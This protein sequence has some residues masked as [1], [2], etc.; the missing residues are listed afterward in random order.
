MPQF[1]DRT[2]RALIP[3][4]RRELASNASGGSNPIDI[5]RPELRTFRNDSA[6]TIPAFGCMRITDA[7]TDIDTD[8]PMIVVGKPNSTGGPFI[9]NGPIEV[10]AGKYGQYQAVGVVDAYYTA[11][12]PT[13]GE[14]W[15]P[16]SNWAISSSGDAA[17][18][19]F[20]DVASGQIRGR[21][22]VAT[23]ASAFAVKL[24][25]IAGSDGTA[26]TSASWR[27]R[28]SLYNSTA[29]INA[30][31]NP[32]EAP[33]EAKRPLG[34]RSKATAGVATYNSNN[35]IIILTTNETITFST[36]E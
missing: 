34:K 12:T 30:D 36:C 24:E 23:A 26:S 15:G 10:E 21:Q 19:I 14:V 28:V 4:A 16:E 8:A 9:F 27:Y 31:V 11:G 18:T 35:E 13:S 5:S 3:V 17:I 7:E 32:G 22:S 20:G 6:E 1:T 29:I 25:H 2:A 33:H